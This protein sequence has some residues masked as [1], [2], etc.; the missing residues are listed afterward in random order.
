M[1]SI[2]WLENNVF[3]VA[4]TPTAFGNDSAPNTT[5]FVVTRQQNPGLFS[6]R[7]LPELCAPYGLNRSPPN[8]FLQRLKDFP[9]NLQDVILVASTAADDIG[10]FSRSRVPLSSDFPADSITNVFT[11]TVM[12]NDARRASLPMP[13]TEGLNET[14][15]IGTA[16]DLSAKENVPRPLPG[17]EMDESPGPLPAFMVLNNE[18]TLVSWWIVYADSI[19]QGTTYPGLLPEGT[20]SQPPVAST[21]STPAFSS[22][23]TPTTPAFGQAG[24]GAPASK[25][26]GS[27]FGSS[28]TANTTGGTAFGSTSAF[29]NPQSPWAGNA[30]ASNIPQASTTAFGQPSF[31]STS[32]IGAFNQG[33]A[34]GSTGGL[35][36]S[37]SPWGAPSNGGP[38]TGG[39]VFGQAS[40]LGMRSGNAFG[41]APT[42]N[43]FGT[44]DA[45]KTPF[46][47]FAGKGG[48]A[49]TAAQSGGENPFAKAGSGNSFGS[50]MDTDN[51]FGGTPKKPVDTPSAPFSGN[52]FS[53]GS[54]FDKPNK[55]KSDGPDP[56]PDSTLGSAFGSFGGALGTALGDA[57]NKTSQA[58][59]KEAD[60]DDGDN[61]MAPSKAS[62]GSFFGQ[63]P[64]NKATQPPA[65]SAPKSGGFFGTQAQDNT[66]PAVM[67]NSAPAPSIF[68]KPT[69]GTASKS[70]TQPTVTQPPKYGGLFG[71]QAQDKSTPAAVQNSAPATS[72]FGK[73]SHSTTP[74]STPKKP[75]ET[76]KPSDT[77]A[78]PIVKPEPEDAATPTGVSK[79][80][81]EAPLPPESTSKASY[82]PGDSSNSSKSSAD[83]APLPPDWT[84]A[85]T[86]LNKEA[87]PPADDKSSPDS[88]PNDA[89]LPPDFMPK[90][91]L[92]QTQLPP[93]EENA[94]LPEDDDEDEDEEDEE[95]EEEDEEEDEEDEESALPEDD[96]DEGWD[97]EGSGVDV[98]QEMSPTDQGQSFGPTPGSSFGASFERSP[99]GE[100]L[101]NKGQHQPSRQSVNSLFG[102]VGQSKAPHLPP[103]TKT[104]ESPRSPSPIRLFP[105]RD[106]LRP[107]NARSV[108]APNRPPNFMASR[109][110]GAKK[111]GSALRSQESHQQQRQR[112]L[113]AILAERSRRQAEEEQDLTDHED[114]RVRE[115]LGADIE[116][117]KTL[118][119]F[120]A[121]QDYVGG[122]EKPGLPGQIEKVY[123]DINSMV[124]TLGLNARSLQAF[125][126]GHSELAKDGGRSMDDLDDEDWCLME[127]SDLETLEDQL[128]AHLQNKRLQ[129]VQQKLEDCQGFRRELVKNH[130]KEAEIKRVIDTRADPEQI[131]ELQAAPLKSEY[132]DQQNSLRKRFTEVQKQLAD[133]EENITMLRT[134]LASRDASNGKGVSLKKPTVE[135][136]TNTILKMTG[137]VEKKSGDIDVLENQMRKLRFSSI[138][139][140][141]QRE[142]PPFN[143]A[144]SMDRLSGLMNA[145]S[146][147]ADAAESPRSPF[148]RSTGGPGT[149]RKKMSA[150]TSDEV[151]RLQEKTK[152]RKEISRMVQEAFLKTGPRIRT[153]E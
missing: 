16:L 80:I 74:Q 146:L 47:G 67:Q 152:R 14:S 73:P 150:F 100:K 55:D 12:A 144:A 54:T 97:D 128:A 96:E 121:H 81:P 39:T 66:T 119:E 94:A 27:L 76:P 70:E 141:L 60:M 23:A 38:Q 98:A 88:S 1:S 151:S 72:M 75:A 29:G 22:T 104:K 77:P 103:P 51:S 91:K 8:H 111:A 120:V 3:L 114:E 116:A 118:D 132:A 153:L 41:G 64:A 143:P 63:D 69:P 26:A 17:E 58:Q 24:L 134:S 108:S 101:L 112:E 127:V 135:A 148:R 115:E 79:A 92:K 6:F 126:K 49:Q 95:E 86:K 43:P 65:T 34:F 46:A 18:G 30:P 82:A 149:P 130:S 110:P 138:N 28:N 90:A 78:S 93:E 21:Q 71:T 45:G 147:G 40:G 59:S 11:T 10:L 145:T 136:V 50:N 48:F 37:G 125:V 109:K 44:T 113:D 32:K 123:R 4:H 140:P 122:A 2:I 137:M 106:N 9:P 15:P 139:Q 129:D 31:A 57:Q 20:Q 85:P 99:L 131:E 133:V 53:L 89:P 83:D 42:A 84:P 25:P 33:A 68:D 56:T 102:E 5:F 117:T 142:G 61:D 105:S 52:A 7:R 124:D 87:K 35:G 62:S 36:K 107:D 19:R 13:L